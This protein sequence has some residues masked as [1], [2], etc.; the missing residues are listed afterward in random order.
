MLK[1]PEDIAVAFI[2]A[3]NNN[4]AED[5]AALF[6]EDAEFGNVTG[7]WWHN[8]QSIL[9]AHRYGFQKIFSGATAK[10]KRTKVSGLRI[11]LP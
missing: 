6:A 2:E 7:L 10:I 9:K 8:R 3:W 5:I 11:L 1:N 4:N